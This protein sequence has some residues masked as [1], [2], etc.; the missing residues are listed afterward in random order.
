MTARPPYRPIVRGLHRC[1]PSCC[2]LVAGVPWLLV[3]TV[4][5]PFPAE[6]WTWPSR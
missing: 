4:G 5:N 2:A 6:G 3:A 1:W